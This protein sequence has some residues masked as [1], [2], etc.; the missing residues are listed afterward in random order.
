[1][2]AAEP[3]RASVRNNYQ[4]IN[5]SL[6]LRIYFFL[7]YDICGTTIDM[8]RLPIAVGLAYGL[9]SRASAA[10]YDLP[11]LR[12]SQPV[13]AMAPVKIVGSATVTRRTGFYV[14]CDFSYNYT[15][16]VDASQ[17]LTHLSLGSTTLEQSVQ[18][19]AMAVLGRGA[20]DAFGDGAF[21]GYNTQWQDLSHR[22]PG[23]AFV[24]EFRPAC[25]G[26]VRAL[27]TPTCAQHG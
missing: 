7:R 2:L 21:L 20:D 11:I 6:T 25:R 23:I 14:G 3:S 5:R 1:L 4:K 10:D 27:C 22:S 8:C 12:G 24:S 16:F 18:P 19:S 9:L 13:A 17:P 15:T 26:C